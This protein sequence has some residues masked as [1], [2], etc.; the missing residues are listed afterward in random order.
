MSDTIA[1]VNEIVLTRGRPRSAAADQ[2]IL[3]AARQLLVADGYGGFTMAGVAA[4]AGVSTATLYR[5]YQHRDE[6]VVAALADD[7]PDALPDTGTLRGDITS[8]LRAGARKLGGERGQLIF[9]IVGDAS[10]NP[11][12]RDL[13]RARMAASRRAELA[14]I[15]QRA[16]DRDEMPPPADMNLVIDLLSAPLFYRLV[17][18]GG[19]INTRIADELTDLILR[20]VG[21]N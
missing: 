20:A 6:L 2:A 13:L 1:A 17:V 8:I 5:R 3:L 18:S 15:F 4:A 11:A 7:A 9:A 21:A 10:R 12:L 16:I 14:T 19:P